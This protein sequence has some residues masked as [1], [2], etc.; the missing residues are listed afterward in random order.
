MTEADIELRHLY[1]GPGKGCVWQ[2]VHVPT[3]KYV[4]IRS[5]TKQALQEA[6][7]QLVDLVPPKNIRLDPAWLTSTVKQLAQ[8]IYDDRA[9]ERMPILADA[10][11]DAGCD[12]PDVLNHCRS[13]GEHV[14]GCWVVD[15]MLD[16]K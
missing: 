2:A 1:F 4:Q 6:Y 10:L 15:A 9:F 11:E 14:R 16:K 5:R 3:G 7:R 13:A 8:S 12:N